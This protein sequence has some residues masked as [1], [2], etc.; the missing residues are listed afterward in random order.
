MDAH[1]TKKVVTVTGH[2]F[3]TLPGHVIITARGQGSSTR[4]AG[5]RAMENLLSD[6]QL[7]NR[8]VRSFKVGVVIEHV[9]VTK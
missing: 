4:V 8:R 5:M 1:K 7:K 3:D 2:A 6:R 9:E